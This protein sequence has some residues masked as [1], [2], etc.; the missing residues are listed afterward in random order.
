MRTARAVADEQVGRRSRGQLE[1]EILGALWAADHPLTP[2]DVLEAIGADIAYVTVLS[3]LIR[4]HERGVVEREKQGRAHAY[5]PVRSRAE[6]AAADMQ[7]L[8]DNAGDRSTVLQQ[9]L[10]LLPS[11]DQETLRSLVRRRRSA[12]N[13]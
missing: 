8:L 12:K 9:F 7:A 13:A 5:H 6:T 2:G 1:A 11:S 4:L 10:E 3:T